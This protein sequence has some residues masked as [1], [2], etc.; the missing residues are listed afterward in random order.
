[1][2]DSLSYKILIVFYS[3]IPFQKNVSKNKE[4]KRIFSMMI[5]TYQ[6]S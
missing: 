4:N 2:K 1:M 5:A 6:T 3:Q